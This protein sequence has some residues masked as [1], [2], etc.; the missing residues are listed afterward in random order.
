[1][2]GR[3]GNPLLGADDVGDLH[4][5]V[6]HDVGQVIGGE[7]VGLEQHLVVHVVVG[8]GDGAAKF[9]AEGGLALGGDLQ[10]D[11]RRAASASKAAICAG[12]SSRCAPL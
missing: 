6:V 11:D 4:Q 8:E 3:G 10:A 1:M 7:A 5:V 9:V 2:L 12:V